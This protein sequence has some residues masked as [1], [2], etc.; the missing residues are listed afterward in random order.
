MSCRC[1]DSRFATLLDGFGAAMYSGNEPAVGIDLGTTF[2]VI[3]HLD[4]AGRPWTIPNSEGDL[5]T[6]SA[7]F[8]DGSAMIVGKEAIKTAIAAPEDVAQFVKR[9]MGCVAYRKPINGESV[10][11]EI[12]HAR[13][14]AARSGQ[15]AADRTRSFSCF[16]LTI[17]G[18][19]FVF[20]A[21]RMKGPT[22]PRP[23]TSRAALRPEGIV[24]GSRLACRLR[25]VLRA[26]P[27]ESA[28]EADTRRNLPDFALRWRP[29]RLQPRRQSE[30]CLRNPC[31]AR[32]A[33]PPMCGG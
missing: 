19:V 24:V 31:L 23:E 4:S 3:A 9:D 32:R 5:I 14:N 25:P 13:R 17:V 26:T 12:L 33:R 11:P 18:L 30:C 27:G 2:S 8:F 1:R 21:T 16:S 28:P 10:P 15:V 20:W 22:S 7:V 6:P 29:S